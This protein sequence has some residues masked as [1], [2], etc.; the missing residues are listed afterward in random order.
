MNIVIVGG[1]LTGA[2]AVEELRKQGYDD[3]ITLVAAERH[4]PYDRP[5]LSK[6]FLLGQAEI[7]S[8]YLHDARWYADHNVD[9]RL[10]TPVTELDLDRSRVTVAGASVPYDR[11]LLATGSTPRR[12]PLVDTSGLQVTYLRTIDDALTLKTRLSG[13]VLILGGGWIGL[14]VAAAARQAGATVTLVERSPL[15]LL[16]VLGSELGRLFA[17]LHGQHGVDLRL[18]TTA[19][20]IRGSEVVLSDGHRLVPDTVVVA[21]GASPVTDVAARAGLE[22]DN[23]VLVDARLRTRDPHVYAAGDVANHDH[24]TIGRLR[25][26]HWDN[27]IAQGQHA[28]RVMLGSDH[29]YTRHPYFFTDQYDLGME[30]VGTT[31]GHDR[32]LI[33]GSVEERVV[34]AFWL[35]RGTVIAGMHINHWDAIEPIRRIVGQQATTQ[36]FDPDVELARA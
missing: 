3:D 18:G 2:H 24:P 17:D 34:T 23:G 28:S 14:E 21:I 6:D 15:P 4:L 12:L 10:G 11:L 22:V 16:G 9:L 36:L 26:E 7:D 33:R 1:G 27:A 8:V 30:F 20:S 35:R 29:P 5:P 25:V 32:L 31:T 19:E 13:H